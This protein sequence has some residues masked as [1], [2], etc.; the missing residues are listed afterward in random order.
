MTQQSTPLRPG[1]QLASTS[2]AT[3]VVVVKAPAGDSVVL[4]CGGA[5]MVPAATAEKIAGDGGAPATLLGPEVHEMSFVAGGRNPASRNGR[6]L[7]RSPADVVTRHGIG[8]YA[9]CPPE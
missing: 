2:C 7:L 6:L 3:R 1:D 8:R 9:L 5:P 4:T